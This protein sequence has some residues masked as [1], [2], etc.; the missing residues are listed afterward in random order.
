[1]H[2]ILDCRPDTTALSTDPTRVVHIAFCVPHR[3]LAFTTS[4]PTGVQLRSAQK[5]AKS[6]SRVLVRGKFLAV[7]SLSEA[8]QCDLAEGC[9]ASS[10]VHVSSGSDVL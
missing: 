6:T 3:V 9:A 10:L 8:P 2:R 1:M 4:L 5:L 7:S